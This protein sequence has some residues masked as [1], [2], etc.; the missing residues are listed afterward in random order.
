MG[1]TITLNKLDVARAAAKAY[2]EGSLS[3]Q[4]A[5]PM[6]RYR[7]PSGCP[8]VIGAAIDA[9]TAAEWD[10]RG[11]EIM[12]GVSTLHSEGLLATDDLG[13]LMRLQMYH[14]SWAD[15]DDDA[16]HR[17]VDILNDILPPEERIS[18]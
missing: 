14:D 2:R 6:C 10:R 8:C 12:T 4:G 9:D 16:E 5:T 18:Q 7:D 17:L 3:A 1:D 11:P 15:G 13:T